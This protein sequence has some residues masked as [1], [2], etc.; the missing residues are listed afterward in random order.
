MPKPRLKPEEI[1]AGREK[2]LNEACD[3]ICKYGFYRLTMRKLAAKLKMSAGN[4]YHYYSNKDEIYLAIQIKGFQL[5]Y[6]RFAK[7]NNTDSDPSDKLREIIKAYL[8]FGIKNAD[9]YNVM[10]TSNAPRYTDYVGEKI[11][12][13]ALFEKQSSLRVL[14]IVSQ[15]LCDFFGSN[16]RSIHQEARYY[17]IHAWATLHGIV[18]LY[19]ARVLQELEEQ[20]EQLLERITHDFISLLEEGFIGKKVAQKNIIVP[21]NK[22]GKPA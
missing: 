15:V 19:H 14:D 11:E 13:L 9:H 7:I 3:A 17:T 5:L 10:F 12:A 8:D 4:L 21:I 1:Q 6:D 2:I 22:G 20:T 18:S 16:D